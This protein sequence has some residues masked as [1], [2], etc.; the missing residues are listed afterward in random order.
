MAFQGIF[1]FI[2]LLSLPV[3]P[4]SPRWLLQHDMLEEAREVFARFQGVKVLLNDRKVLE[5]L[6][7]VKASIEEERRLGQASWAE[8]FFEGKERNLSRVLLGAGPYL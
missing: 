5:E 7:A 8:V 6:D 4:E 1:V 2:I 3:L